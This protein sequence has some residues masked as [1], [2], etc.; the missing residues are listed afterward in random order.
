MTS[1]ARGLAAAVLFLTAGLAPPARADYA[2]EM[3]SGA[4]IT[5]LG[6]G[7][8]RLG[9]G[10]TLLARY[11][12]SLAGDALRSEV[13]E[14]FRHLAVDARR[15]RTPKIAVEAHGAGA[16]VTFRF[17]VVDG[18]FRHI[19]SAERL[20]AGLDDGFV[21]ALLARFDRA[22]EVNMQPVILA[23]LANEWTLNQSDQPQMSRNEY[24]WNVLG[25]LDGVTNRAHR[26]EILD[27]VVSRDR[28]TARIESREFDQG[29]HNGLTREVTARASDIIAVQGMSAVIARSSKAIDSRIETHTR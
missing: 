14:F 22:Y 7:P 11:R 10:A 8:E 18:A 13:D 15:M 19:E 26:R 24:F 6:D 29:T 3:Q 9:D 28:R 4:R 1:T 20:A 5:I 12:T 25:V 23:Y 2:F 27:I 17:E 16:P 21:R